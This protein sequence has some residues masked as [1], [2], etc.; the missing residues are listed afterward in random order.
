MCLLYSTD[1]DN[2]LSY[3]FTIHKKKSATGKQSKCSGC[4]ICCFK[5]LFKFNMHSVA[6][7]NLYLA[8]EFILTLSFT[9]VNCERSFSKLKIIK[10]RLRS[11]IG[12]EKLEAFMLMSV[13]KELLEEV[14]FQE[15][16]QYVKQ[17]SSLM[18]KLL[19]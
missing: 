9:Q 16:L 14:D 6:F 5:L 19:S 11:S 10:S 1:V 18:C 2:G 12:N 8:Y 13:E 4:L 7:T 17:S 15:I 3:K